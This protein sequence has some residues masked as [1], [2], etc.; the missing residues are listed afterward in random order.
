MLIACMVNAQTVIVIE[1]SVA[2]ITKLRA[3]HLREVKDRK[4]DEVKR[5]LHLTLLSQGFIAYEMVEDSG[6]RPDSILVKPGKAYSWGSITLDKSVSSTLP[7]SAW[8]R[9]DRKAG[10]PLD[11][12]ALRQSFQDALSHYE[13][14]GYPFANIRLDSVSFHGLSVDAVLR[15]ETG[16]LITFDTLSIK[17]YRQ[18]PKGFLAHELGIMPNRPYSEKAVRSIPTG[19]DGV[20][21]LSLKLQPNVRFVDDRAL[22]TLFVVPT[23]ASRFDGVIGILPSDE[24]GEFVITGDAN[25]HLEN[26]LKMAEVIDIRWRRLQANTQ[27]LEAYAQLPYLFNTIISP[28]TNVK[29]YR[30]DTSFTDLSARLGLRFSLGPNAFVTAFGEQQTTRLIAVQQY[31]FSG[32]RPPFLDRSVTSF[33]LSAGIRKL[34]YRLNPSKGYD[35]LVTSGVGNKQILIN[36]QLPMEVYE[37]LDLRS[38]QWNSSADLRYYIS[39]VS[40]LVWHQQY[41]GGWL[42]NEQLLNNEATRLGGLKTIRGFN[43]ESLFA[44]NYLIARNEVRYQIERN[45][46][47]FLFGDAMWYE[48]TSEHHIGPRRDTPLAT[49]AGITFGTRAGIFS[50]SA[51][52][53]RQQNN[54]MLLRTAKIHFGFLNVF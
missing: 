4:I 2:S 17:N 22:V 14:N 37:D 21:F 3:F 24:P 5:D 29:I 16:P 12:E 38:L 36:A 33:G 35:L 7:G 8:R 46:Y 54:P 32:A 51:A 34:D 43:E 41:L 15:I 23:P 25:V 31:Q 42:F 40:R 49:G 19:M 28:I 26:A 47:V 53:G 6:S 1:D 30:R 52:L 13:N 48:N 11:A 10:S 18:F 20:N 45:G 44:T 27:D 39:P 50:F 9:L